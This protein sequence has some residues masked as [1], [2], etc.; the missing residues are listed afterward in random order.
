M[1]TVKIISANC[2]GLQSKQKRYD[3]INYMKSK[4][5][6]ILCLQDTHLKNED[7]YNLKTMWNGDVILHGIHTNSRGVAILLNNTFEYSIKKFEKD[8]A[9]NMIILNLQ[10][11]DISVKLINI[12]GPNTDDHEFYNIIGR[13][14]D[15]NEQDYIIWCG[16]FNLT[17]NPKLDCFNYSN[18]NNPKSRQTTLNI[19]EEYNLVDTYRHFYP[20]CLRY[21]WRRH[22]PLKQ[23]RLDYFIVSS[24]LTD[25][26]DNIDIKPGYKSD[27]SMLE[28]KIV[29]NRFKLGKGIW[30][31]NTSLLKDIEYLTQIRQ[32]IKE[33]IA[34][35]AVPL[36]NL[37]KL[38]KIPTNQIQLTIEDDVF[39][40][41]L[42]LRIRGETLKYSSLKR[43]QKE[44]SET[45]LISEIEKLENENNPRDTNVINAKK[46][47]LFAIRE[48]KMKGHYI[49]SR[50]Q[51]LKD[52]ERP[53]K[54]FCS[55]E[56]HN[57]LNKTIKKLK[58]ND[59]TFITNQKDILTE[60]TNFYTRLFKSYDNTL[61]HIDLNA[62]LKNANV[63]KLT[64]IQAKSL[65]GELKEEE[66][67]KALKDMKSNKTPGID[68][69]P[70]EFFKF[71][72]SN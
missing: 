47:E 11:S 39:L 55:L 18:I 25:L 60:L 49:R 15:E 59:N 67:S 1:G 56:H 61:D 4:K 52:G 28:L 5:V 35:Y 34:R 23:A 24:N 22:N 26:I 64:A 40:E 31:F 51:W 48:A 6:D 37:E 71:F 12:Y 30:K 8:S 70:A 72:G 42:I 65:E 54:F 9:G 32:F 27:H 57:Y 19:I 10:I 50:V 36:Y 44:N 7:E 17:L 20:D 66:L 38:D 45:E 63:H 13:H 58:K 41:T 21:T 62:L 14:I 43:K 29:L 33:E 69:F 3:V 46:Q 16:D 68:G 2:R 53:T